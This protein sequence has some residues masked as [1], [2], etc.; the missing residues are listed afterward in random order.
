MRSLRP[1]VTHKFPGVRVNAVCPSMTLT[2]MVDGVV[3]DWQKKNLPVNLPQDIASVLVGIAAAGPGSDAMWYDEQESPG[4]RA[5]ES[6]GSTDWDNKLQAGLH[7][8]ALFV[9]G[10]KYYDIEEGLEKT[11]P[12][13]L[14]KEASK[15]V[16]G[17]QES[18]GLGDKWINN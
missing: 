5:R 10:R 18:L 11:E 6:V 13:W 7:G 1:Y 4:L 15:N 16:K 8:R 14:G 2:N 17:A 3:G 12:I 9:L